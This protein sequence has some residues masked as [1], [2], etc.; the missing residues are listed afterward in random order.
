MNS[1]NTSDKYQ[2]KALNKTDVR[3]CFS[4][5]LPFY[6]YPIPDENRIKKMFSEFEIREIGIKK[7]PI[8]FVKK[9]EQSLIAIELKLIGLLM[10]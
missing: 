1:E 10:N 7:L 9:W 3:R 8:G 4:N 6:E 5:S 2:A